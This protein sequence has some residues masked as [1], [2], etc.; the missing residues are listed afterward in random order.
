MSAQSL[1]RLGR[2]GGEL[3]Q[4]AMPCDPM[5]GSADTGLLVPVKHHMETTTRRREILLCVDPFSPQPTKLRFHCKYPCGQFS[6]NNLRSILKLRHEQEFKDLTNLQYF[7]CYVADISGGTESPL[8]IFD[9][10]K[11]DGDSVKLCWDK[12]CCNWQRAI[13][14]CVGQSIDQLSSCLGRAGHDLTTVD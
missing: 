8:N 10:K 1:T 5:S 3:W 12:K 7:T 9:V 4:I 14:R 6:A 11:T 2:S 13:T